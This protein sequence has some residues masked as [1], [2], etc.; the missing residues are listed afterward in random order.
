MHPIYMSIHIKR[1][2]MALAVNLFLLEGRTRDVNAC[3]W[4]HPSL[5]FG[6]AFVPWHVKLMHIS[7]YIIFI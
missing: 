3:P 4:P 5:L 2:S 7:I 1:N 6:S